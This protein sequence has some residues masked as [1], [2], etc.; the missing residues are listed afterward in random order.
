MDFADEEEQPQAW[1]P[2]DMSGEEDQ[3]C[4]EEGCGLVLYAQC[5]YCYANGCIN[6]WDKHV[7]AGVERRRADL[8]N[9][10]NTVRGGAPKERRPLAGVTRLPAPVIAIDDFVVDEEVARDDDLSQRSA[11][12][13]CL[14]IKTLTTKTLRDAG[15]QLTLGGQ[16]ITTPL[17]S[18]QI[19]ERVESLTAQLI[20][21]CVRV[22]NTALNGE[23]LTV[24]GV[25]LTPDVACAML[26]RLIRARGHMETPN[27][28][29]HALKSPHFIAEAAKA[30]VKEFL[31]RCATYAST[32]ANGECGERMKYLR[33]TFHGG[34]AV[35]APPPAPAPKK[36]PVV[37][38]PP[39]SAPKPPPK[40]RP[41]EGP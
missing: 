3:T 23:R 41:H 36:L 18:E 28:H 33:Q 9:E 7:C 2:P 40:K 17:T 11:E 37:M 5:R 22:G 26:V 27:G 4:A 14:L 10:E 34:N 35:T 20:A 32:D 13:L 25:V 39:K 1:Q 16:R 19:K 15:S 30:V 31:V 8:A 6:H 21:L 24:C 38:S 29:N 12:T